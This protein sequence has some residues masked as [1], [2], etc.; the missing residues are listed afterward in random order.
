MKLSN[1]N[2]KKESFLQGDSVV[3]MILLA[4]CMISIVEV[5]SA[6]SRMTYA[7]ARYWG[8]V[9]EHTSYII[10]GL[11][12][13]WVIHKMPCTSFK[14]LSVFG[15]LVAFILLFA[16]LFMG[17][18]NNAARWIRIAGITIQPSE[19]AKLTLVGTVAT[20]LA[21]MRDKATGGASKQA[22]KWVAG[23]TAVI[24]LL[25]VG[26][27]FSTAGII[28][29]VI[30]MMTWIA[31]APKKW[32]WSIIIGIVMTGSIGYC[33]LKYV[34]DKAATAISELPLLHRFETWSKRVKSGNELPADPKEYNIHDNIQVTHARIAVA[35][36]NVI[37]KGPGQ[38]VQRDFLPHAVSD[39]IY[40]IIIEEGGI[41]CGILVMFMYLLL[42]YRAM[43]I[44]ERCKNRFPAYLVMGLSLML[45]VQAMVNMA[46]SVGAMPVT[47]QPLPL[48]SKGGTSTFITC[49]YIGMILSVSYTAKQIEPTEP[50]KET[51]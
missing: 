49:A 36:C 38:S 32:L 18:I 26:E 33:T 2:I 45:V 17:R 41:E 42:L 23:L 48:V 39:F 51:T 9:V 21:T 25:I 14:F 30:F 1:I 43:R 6:S 29:M 34:P 37:G 22:F 12:I 10:I 7:S 44:A 20:L 50:E 47:G 8:P 31:Q 19:F 11:F 40:A 13:T 15:L 35:T 16:V 46:V 28:F 3:W 5:Y 27:N 4:L 24:C